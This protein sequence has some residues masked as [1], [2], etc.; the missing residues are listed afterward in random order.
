M[1][2]FE[3][4]HFVVRFGSALT[5][6]NPI[7]AGV[8][9]GAA[10]APLSFNLY[11]TDQPTTNHTI[12]GDFVDDKAIMVLNSEPGIKTGESR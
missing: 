11:T 12:T 1:S 10:A 3:D 2:Y 6:I 9:Q 5:K 8:S 7:H 4:R